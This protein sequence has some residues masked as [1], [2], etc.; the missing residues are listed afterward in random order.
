M[1]WY[2]QAGKIT[3]NIKV[4]IYFT[5]PE[6]SAPKIVTWN[7]HVDNS[8]KGSYYMILGRDLWTSLVL[9]LKLS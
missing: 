7:C 4:Q 2:K 9:N 3:T 5:L 1:Q 6:I 8:S